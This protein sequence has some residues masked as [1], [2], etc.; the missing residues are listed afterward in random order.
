MDSVAYA[1]DANSG[2]FVEG[3]AYPRR[4]C[5]AQ[6]SIFFRSSCLDSLGRYQLQ[7]SVDCYLNMVNVPIDNLL[8]IHQQVG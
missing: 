5:F 8:R 2:Y 4:G 7:R 6:G 3:K 1:A